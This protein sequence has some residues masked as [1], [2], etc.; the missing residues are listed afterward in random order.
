MP[1]DT[2]TAGLAMALRGIY[3]ARDGVEPV[4]VAVTN[5]ADAIA[6]AEELLF[7]IEEALERDGLAPE[8]LEDDADDC[9]D[10]EPDDE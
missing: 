7:D 6:T 5:I 10:E 3:L 4:N 9:D 2:R 8:D 1:D